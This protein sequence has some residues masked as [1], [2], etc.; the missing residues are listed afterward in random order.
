MEQQ[1][2]ETPLRG[3]VVIVD[4]NC[5]QYT[6]QYTQV[7]RESNNTTGKGRKKSLREL[8][9]KREPCVRVCLFAFGSIFGLALLG[10]VWVIHS[11]AE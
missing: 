10:W 7:E 11:T 9:K 4:Y 8:K 6:V 3:R 2:G 5:V 1:Q